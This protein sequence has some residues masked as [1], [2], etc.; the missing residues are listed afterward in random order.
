MSKKLL[1]YEVLLVASGIDATGLARF[2][3]LLYKAGCRVTLLSPPGLAV[4]RSR[5]VACHLPTSNELEASA[6]HLKEVLSTQ[7]PPFTHVLIGDEPILIALAEHQGEAWLDSFFPV[8][9]RS[10]AVEIILSKHTFYDEMVGAGLYMPYSKICQGWIEVEEAVK[11]AGY[12]VILK[13]SHGSTGSAVHKVHDSSELKPCY[14]DLAANDEPL[15]VQQFCEGALGATDVLYDH[16]VPVCWQSSYKPESWPTPLSASS[17]R[18]MMEHPDIEHII[19]EVG[20]ITGFHGFAAVDWIQET[21]SDRICMLELN[22]RPTPSYHLDRHSG[23]SFSHSFN[24]LL[25]GQRTITPPKPVSQPAP[26]IKLFPQSLYWAIDNKSFRGF[27][28]CWNDAPWYDPLLLA[29]YL[30]RVLVHYMPQRWR[31]TL[32]RYVRKN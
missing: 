12:P 5:F 26:L 29:A 7:N 32:K 19:S 27:I 15:L 11:R 18:I 2:P 13:A 17:A 9:H 16:G 8:D 25:S 24:Q 31:D 6:L 14:T 21:S 23:I 1:P 30:R 10:K 28:L 20:R 4:N 22:P 3:Y